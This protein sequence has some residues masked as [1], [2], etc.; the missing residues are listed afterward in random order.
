MP[1]WQSA[2]AINVK[3]ENNITLMFKDTKKKQA[4]LG[5]VHVHV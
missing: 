2:A 4:D 1:Y 5:A 3:K